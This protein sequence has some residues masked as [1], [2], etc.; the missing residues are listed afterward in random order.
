MQTKSPDSTATIALAGA[1]FGWGSTGKL[2]ALIATLRDRSP[3]PLRFVGI[4]S[5]LGRALLTEHGID[6][7]YDARADDRQAVA[8]VARRENVSAGLV[9]LEGPAATALEAAGVP[10]VF[11]DSLPFLW[12]EGDRDSL[13]TDVS[14]Y[15][16]Q[17][18]VDLPAECRGVLASITNLQWVEAVMAVPGR[19]ISAGSPAGPV[20]GSSVRRALVS[21]GGLRSPTLTDWTS[22]PSLVIPA[23][24]EALDSLGVREVH[25]AGNLPDGFSADAEHSS[26]MR[27][28]YGPLGHEAFLERLADTDVLLTS[29][30]LTTLLE[31]GA[32]G[33]PTVCLPPQNLS[34]IFNGRFHS[35]AV[36]ADVRVTW[37]DRVFA[38]AEVLRDR[39]TAEEA[40]LRLIYTGIATAAVEDAVRTRADIRDGVLAALRRA[41][42]GARW[43]AL[44]DTVGR[45][46]AAQ[47]AD[48]V[49]NL[50]P[51]A[52]IAARG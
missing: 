14:V 4:A 36:G 11:V 37:P 52:A 24:L 22:Y 7:W 28:T 19:E 9:V 3:I 1:E 41:G 20:P 33:T 45:H 51:R 21:L 50:V 39:T 30:G 8:D 46:G 13:P 25:V 10:T 6:R 31:A 12:T 23:A 2:S 48:H 18:C 26:R 5:G 49:L 29:P 42:S 47:V 32:R 44:V 38:E 40:A 34:Q 16:A 43:T 15:C 27:V 17:R 35:R